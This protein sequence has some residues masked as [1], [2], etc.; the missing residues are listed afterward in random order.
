MQNADFYVQQL[1]S[2]ATLVTLLDGPAFGQ[3]GQSLRSRLEL[4]L[5]LGL[6][7]ILGLGLIFLLDYLDTSI[8]TRQDLDELGL[9]VVGEIPRGKPERGQ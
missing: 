5:R 6:A 8:R 1:G 4:P 7:L 3:V 2:D 9:A